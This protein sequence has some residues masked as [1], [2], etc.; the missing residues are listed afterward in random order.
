[1]NR[2]QPGFCKQIPTYKHATGIYIT[3]LHTQIGYVIVTEG[4]S[5]YSFIRGGGNRA[6][7]NSDS[8]YVHIEGCGVERKSSH[9]RAENI[10]LGQT[11]F[12]R[13]LHSRKNKTHH[14]HG[15]EFFGGGNKVLT[16]FLLC[17]ILI[18]Y[19]AI[20]SRNICKVSISIRWG[21]N[22]EESLTIAT[23]KLNNNLKL[24][25]VIKVLC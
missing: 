9:F 4:T 2:S 24:G 21:G 13:L 11:N 19:N 16:Q 14:F 8:Y 20:A 10:D 18:T 15:E 22:E 5:I 1:M 25:E 12:R 3:L 23:K 6:T 17:L 7:L